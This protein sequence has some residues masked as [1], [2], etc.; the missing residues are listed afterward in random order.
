MSDVDGFE[1]SLS[2]RSVSMLVVGLG[3]VVGFGL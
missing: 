3:A 1:P 2:Y